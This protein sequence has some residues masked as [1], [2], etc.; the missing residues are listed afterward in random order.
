MVAWYCCICSLIYNR[1]TNN[2]SKATECE[3]CQY[4]RCEDCPTSTVPSVLYA[5]EAEEWGERAASELDG[6]EAEEAWGW[7]SG[8]SFS[9]GSIHSGA[10]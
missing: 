5:S 7:G 1:S 3:Y 6:E 4:L 10:M 2:D 9:T 8:Y